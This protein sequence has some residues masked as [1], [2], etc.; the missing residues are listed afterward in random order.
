M[1]FICEILNS[2]KPEIYLEAFYPI[3]TSLG[4]LLKNSGNTPWKPFMRKIS[5]INIQHFDY[6]FDLESCVIYL[7]IQKK[8]NN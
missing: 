1:L 6:I 3:K 5:F 4:Y 2:V 8:D 7:F